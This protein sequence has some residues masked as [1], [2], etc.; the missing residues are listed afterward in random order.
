MAEA[1]PK[2]CGSSFA[3]HNCRFQGEIK[4]IE[5]HC[6]GDAGTW[7]NCQYHDAFG[8]ITE[9]YKRIEQAGLSLVERNGFYVFEA[10]ASTSSPSGESAT[11][12]G[13]VLG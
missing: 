11:M 1:R 3:F 9:K 10:K 2:L 12:C 4:G 8:M 13:A 6:A 5:H 7:G